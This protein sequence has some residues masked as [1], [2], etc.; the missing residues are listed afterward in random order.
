MKFSKKYIFSSN[1][2]SDPKRSR[3]REKLA[4]KWGKPT[5][6]API[7]LKFGTKP[8][9]M[10]PKTGKKSTIHRNTPRWSPK[11]WKSRSP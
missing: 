6:R 7:S 5:V 9:L 10:Y 1:M 11:V 8:V 4:S 2:K 3:L